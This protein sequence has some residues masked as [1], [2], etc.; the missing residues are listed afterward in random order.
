MSLGARQRHPTTGG[1]KRDT[2]NGARKLSTESN[3]TCCC[4][5]L[6]CCRPTVEN[7]G[8]SRVGG[9]VFVTT[10]TPHGYTTGDTVTI[11]GAVPTGYVGS[12]TITVT[13]L[14]TYTYATGLTPTTPASV[15]GISTKD[16][17][18]FC[19]CT[20]TTKSLTFAGTVL[21]STCIEIGGPGAGL[22]SVTTGASTRDGTYCLSQIAGCSWDYSESGN[23]GFVWG[24]SDCSGAPDSE[25]TEFAIGFARTSTTAGTVSA[26]LT[27]TDLPEYS[28]FDS[29]ATLGACDESGEFT[30]DIT[31]FSDGQVL[32][33]S[34]IAT[35]GGCC[36]V[37]I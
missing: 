30:N 25:L 4:E 23:F 14:T 18:Q 12:N 8:I 37:D 21:P 32:G 10:L 36:E 20:Q 9:T 29:S 28:I 27:G 16:G 34:G 26:S 35:V 5:V 22:G 17:C 24:S 33:H 13:G 2:T 11:S 15:P 1:I 7:S 3:T 31:S 19:T 6:E